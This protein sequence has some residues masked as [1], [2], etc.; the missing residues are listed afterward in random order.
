[1]L[2][3]LIKNLKVRTKLLVIA[4]PLMLAIVVSLIA[5][6]ASVNKTESELESVY[7]DTL[8]GIN[9]NL[10]AADR[11]FYQSFVGAT[12]VYDLG[13][14]FT[15]LPKEMQEQYLPGYLD[16]YVTNRQQV[17]DKAAKAAEIAQKDA[18]LFNGVAVDG[19]TFKQSY[20][21][22]VN[23][24]AAWDASYDVAGLSGDWGQYNVTFGTAR[25][26]LDVMQEITDEWAAEK[27]ASVEK[28]IAGIISLLVVAFGL[29]IVVL[30]A[31]T[32]IVIRG[33]TKPVSEVSKQLGEIAAGSLGV[34]FPDDSKI[35]KD[36][37]GDIQRSARE[38]ADRLKEIIGK[39][40]DAASQVDYE[41][42]ELANSASQATDAS[43]QITDAINDI[44]KGASSQADSIEKAAADTGEIGNDIENIADSV[45]NMDTCAG[46]MKT[47]CDK[48]MDAL[49]KLI[50]QSE[51]V[52]QSV[53]EIGDTIKSTNNS[54][55]E[56]SQFTQAITDI[57]SQTNL[58]SLNASIEAARAG[59]AGRG[60]AVVADEIRQL[61][62]QSNESAEQIKSIV[63]RLLTD[64]Q[65]SMSVLDKLNESFGEQATQL[66]ATRSDMEDMFVNAESVKT[67]SDDISGRVQSLESSKNGLT[68][69]ISDLSAI[70]EENAASTEETNAAMEELNATFSL[71]AKAAEGLQTLAKDLADTINYF[72][73]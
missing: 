29:V 28:Q 65:S 53:K 7:Y 22:F 54:A 50:K 64:A 4:I 61:A 19:V 45:N 39:S 6:S 40:K 12:A 21:S 17:Y 47:A 16:D 26:D 10:L 13:N 35:G 31:I 56:I 2:M 33:I 57:A 14:G 48:A 55:M 36:E 32:I 30:L 44:T 46:E 62:D 38:L 63:E 8:Y 37:I 49:N 23:N 43:A 59:E 51:S 34:E 9:N 73:D 60:F 20:E 52:T 58:L 25:N 24:M 67:S 72:H 70:S 66:D 68:E 5:A 3:K 18:S 1:M 11:D 27:K 42:S 15:T 71:I 69:I 41:S